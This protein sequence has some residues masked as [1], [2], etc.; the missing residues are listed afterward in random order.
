MKQSRSV[1]C[2]HHFIGRICFRCFIIVVVEWNNFVRTQWTL[3]WAWQMWKLQN[4]TQTGWPHL[5][6]SNGNYISIRMNAIKMRHYFWMMLSVN[7]SSVYDRSEWN[8][9]VWHWFSSSA[10]KFIQYLNDSQY[11][12]SHRCS[13]VCL[14]VWVSMIKVTG[15]SPTG[16]M[17]VIL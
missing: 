16:I 3:W 15:L 10:K 12:G 13:T 17:M 8:R 9:S 11:S 4:V 5:T 6:E 1:G 14:C 2:R 7:V